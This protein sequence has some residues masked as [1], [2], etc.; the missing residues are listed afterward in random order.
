[1]RSPSYFTGDLRKLKLIDLDTLEER[2]QQTSYNVRTLH[3]FF[4]N[5]RYGLVLSTKGLKSEAQ[6]MSG[7]DFDGDK[8]WVCWNPK[9]VDHVK[10][11][12]AEDTATKDFAIRKSAP[13]ENEQRLHALASQENRVKF[14]LHKRK[15]QHQLG[16][17]SNLLDKTI[18]IHGLR[19]IHGLAKAVGTQGF[20]QV[21]H[22]YYLCELQAAVKE[23]LDRDPKEPPH[24]AP[25]S[26]NS[27]YR[28][29][30]ALGRMW[31][32]VENKIQAMTQAP[33]SG[34]IQANEHIIAVVENAREK[35]AILVE[36]LQVRMRAALKVYAQ[37]MR[38]LVNRLKATVCSEEERKKRTLNWISEYCRQQYTKLIQSESGVDGRNL[39]AAVLYEESLTKARLFDGE[40]QVRHSICFAAI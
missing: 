27:G 1:M 17:L 30:K 21:D 11:L 37:E 22:P 8:A 26:T 16:R 5:L 23:I 40:L 13:G 6:K 15:H 29:S 33:G 39:A 14:S 12:E 25:T 18:D 24:W 9:L 2:A 38:T 7:G 19:D 36:A 32:H 4:R 20:L 34:N 31:D 10:D 35:D 3:R 28:S